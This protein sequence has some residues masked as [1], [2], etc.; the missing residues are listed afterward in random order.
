MDAELTITA[1]KII[2]AVGQ[3]PDLDGLGL[4]GK[5]KAGEAEGYETADPKVFITGDLA[6]GDKTVVWAVRKGKE[7]AQSIHKSL[8]ERGSRL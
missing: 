4:E 5:E 8:Q 3:K 7:A 6:L 1:D 2:L